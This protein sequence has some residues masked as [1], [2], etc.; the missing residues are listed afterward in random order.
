M[1]NV[2]LC[3]YVTRTEV[4]YSSHTTTFFIRKNNINTERGAA[5][6][7]ETG[8]GRKEGT[9]CVWVGVEVRVRVRLTFST[10]L[11]KK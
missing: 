4:L 5:A 3:V 6:N 7:K 8:E 10:F 9:A 1:H 11:L 2:C